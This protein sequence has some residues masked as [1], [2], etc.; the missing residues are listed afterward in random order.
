MRVSAAMYITLIL[1]TQRK[2][3]MEF[4]QNHE[5]EFSALLNDYPAVKDGYDQAI[6]LIE[7]SLFK[8][9]LTLSILQKKNQIKFIMN[10]KYSLSN[11]N[12]VNAYTEAYGKLSNKIYE[13]TIH[14]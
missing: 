4:Y 7:E 6:K 8:D 12:H 9:K 1:N 14:I 13:I 3:I 5:K 2:L 11:V 10:L